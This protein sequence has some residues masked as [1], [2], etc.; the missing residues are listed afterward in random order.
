MRWTEANWQERPLQSLIVPFVVFVSSIL[1]FVFGVALP[2][3][4]IVLE[5]VKDEHSVRK[6]SYLDQLRLINEAHELR[7]V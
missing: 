7:G 3:R 2:H 4:P 5:L 1:C 6:K